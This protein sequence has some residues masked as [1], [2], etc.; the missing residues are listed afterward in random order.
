MTYK[1]ISRSRCSGK[2]TA[3]VSA[4]RITGTHISDDNNNTSV[5]FLGYLHAE[6]NIQEPLNH[7][8]SY[9]FTY[10][11]SSP[12]ANYKLSASNKNETTTKHFVRFEVL[13]AVLMKCTIFWD[14]TPSSPLKFNRHLFFNLE[15]G[16]DMFLLNVG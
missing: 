3:L 13:T 7:F 11:L 8:I 6:F 2:P 5:Q 4:Y 16:G 15:D 9:L 14:I 10:K 1:C 12:Q